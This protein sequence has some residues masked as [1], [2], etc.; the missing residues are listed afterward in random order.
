MTATAP[1]GAVT[2]PILL[3]NGEC[4]VCRVIAHWV[5]SSARREPGGPKIVERRIGDDP[6]A[7]LAINPKLDIW[8]A[9][10]TI[11][12]VMP[13]G[14][15]KVG[16]E[17]VADV[18]RS[19]PNCR[20]FAWSFDVRLLGFRPFQTIL[21]LGY[22]ILSDIRPLLGC[23]SCGIPSPWVRYVGSM[24]KRGPKPA[25]TSPHPISR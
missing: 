7:L 12:L 19:L 8:D 1:P 9:Y 13:D 10:E 20:W 23:E 15:M 18:L 3:F 11:H 5:E 14:S 21:N 25:R 22:V 2:K 24:L 16:G 4:A 6:E 17:A